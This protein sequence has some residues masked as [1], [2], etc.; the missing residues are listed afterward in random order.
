M[1]TKLEEE[2]VK[3]QNFL[4]EEETKH[5]QASGASQERIAQ[6]TCDIEGQKSR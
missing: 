5:N 6:L 3:L 4:H 2:N 1:F